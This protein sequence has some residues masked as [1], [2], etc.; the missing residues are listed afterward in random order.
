MET[1]KTKFVD[2]QRRPNPRFKGFIHGTKLIIKEQGIGG[3]YKGLLPT[4]F[5]QVYKISILY[6]EIL[7]HQSRN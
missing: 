7:G 1:I 2:D 6:I 4:I 3:I 5:K